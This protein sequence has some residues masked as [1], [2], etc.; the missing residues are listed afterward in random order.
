MNNTSQYLQPLQWGERMEIGS[1]CDESSLGSAGEC[2]AGFV[3]VAS[4]GVVPVVGPHAAQHTYP[5]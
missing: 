2:V 1:R 3:D 4:N 5:R